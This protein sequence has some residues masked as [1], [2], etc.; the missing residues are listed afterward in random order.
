LNSSGSSNRAGGFTLIELVISVAVTVVLTTISVPIVSHVLQG[1]RLR[2]AVSNVSGA[3][4]ATRYRAIYQGYPFALTLDKANAT[5][6]LSSKAPS[7]TSFSDVGSAIPFQTA[8]ISLDQDNTLT[9]SPSGVVS[10]SAG[11]P[12]TVKLTYQGKTETI[13]VSSYGN[14]KVTEE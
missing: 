12:I 14:I 7:A 13:T 2:A 1:Y 4:S 5:Y 3:I 6:Q 10:A 8:G 9:F 11:S